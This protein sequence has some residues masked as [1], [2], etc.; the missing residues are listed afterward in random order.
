MR[1]AN[2]IAEIMKREGVEFLIAYPVNQLIEAAAQAD[3]RTIIVRQERTGIHMADAYSR[4]SSGKKVGVFCCQ[5][6]P[7]AENA[8]GGIAQ[9]YS[10]SV[11]M[12][13][14][15][16]GYGRNLTNVY[17][18]FNSALNYRNVTKWSEQVTVASA[19]PEAMRRAFTQARNGRPGPT[20]VE[21]PGDVWREEVEVGDYV[22]TTR[23]RF[24]PDPADV[25]KAAQALIEAERPLI[26]AGQGVHYAEAWD[27]LKELVELLEAPIT[28]S[29]EGKSAFPENH[30][31]SLGSGG[32]A[33]PEQVWDIVQDGGRHLRRRRQLQPHQLWHPASRRARPSSTTP[34]TR[35]T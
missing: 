24:G 29:L 28:T 27:E 19:V 8:F 33:M 23:T 30:P 1:V 4:L 2:A 11:P 17:P 6:G 15:P 14:V 13:F 9:A 34:S 10:E 35:W 5:N 32:R 26:Y 22:P 31:L 18:N 3:I 20:L 7:G 25:A 16:A 12:V 21:I